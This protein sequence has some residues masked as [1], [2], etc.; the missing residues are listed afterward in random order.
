MSNAYLKGAGD[1]EPECTPEPTDAQIVSAIREHAGKVAQ[2]AIES[3]RMD[4]K[5]AL[6]AL[7]KYDDDNALMGVLCDSAEDLLFRGE[8]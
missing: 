7:A 1:F 4:L 2:N 6:V 5:A 3:F 8:I